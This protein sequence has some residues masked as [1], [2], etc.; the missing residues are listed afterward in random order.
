M[1][2][3]LDLPKLVRQCLVYY[4]NNQQK[5]S[6]ADLLAKITDPKLLQL[7][8]SKQ[9]IFVTLTINQELRG[10]I[11]SLTAHRSLT[12][13]LIEHSYNA[14]FL[15]QRFT[16]LPPEEL[17][18]ISIEVSVLSPRVE[19]KYCSLDD[20]FQQIVPQIDGIFLNNYHNS[21]T[22]LPQVW[23]VLPDHKLFF[24]HLCAKAGLA[25]NILVENATKIEKYQVEKFCEKK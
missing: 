7:L 10:C 21:A 14:A 8:K 19:V 13:E 5:I 4:Y 9:A 15:D 16:P 1:L 24:K 3:D 20:L 12:Q 18:Q 23:E 25:Y 17:N 22:F 2:A 6:S 11:G